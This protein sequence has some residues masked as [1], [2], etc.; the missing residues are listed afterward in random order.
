MSEQHH[1]AIRAKRLAYVEHPPADLAT[2]ER[3]GLDGA[4]LEIARG[5]E[6]WCV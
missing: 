4:L 6:Q 2:E 3:S 1:R 5:V